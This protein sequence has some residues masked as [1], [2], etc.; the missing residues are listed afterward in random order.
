METSMTINKCSLYFAGCAAALALS[1]QADAAVFIAYSGAAGPGAAGLNVTSAAIDLGSLFPSF[2]A[3]TS[4][5]VTLSGPSGGTLSL[6]P[7]GNEDLQIVQGCAKSAASC[8]PADW[9]NISGVGLSLGG[10][11]VSGAPPTQTFS[12]FSTP[13]PIHVT[14]PVWSLRLLMDGTIPDPASTVGITGTLD[15]TPVPEAGTLAMILAGILGAGA[16]ARRRLN[17]A[18]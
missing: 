1:V 12:F 2:D 16:I 18:A 14:T 10:G 9:F 17:A 6:G 3:S 11:T 4:L 8:A 15:V 5:G 13:V 7:L